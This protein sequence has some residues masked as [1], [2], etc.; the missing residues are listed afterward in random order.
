MGPFDRVGNELKKG[1]VV[2]ILNGDKMLI[3][4]VLEVKEPSIL[5]PGKDMMQMPG[6]MMI[7]LAPMQ[8]MY[9]IQQR[10]ALN[11]VKIVKPPQ[12]SQLQS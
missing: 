3:G 11:I 2:A 5:T 10:A 4:E 6:I 7:G 12:P 9:T 8:V 1:D